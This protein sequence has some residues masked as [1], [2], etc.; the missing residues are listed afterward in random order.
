MNSASLSRRKF[1]KNALA[2]TA[3]VAAPTIVPAS[4]FGANA[5]SNRIALGCIGVGRMGQGDLRSFM[6]FPEIQVVAVCDVDSNRAKDA[7]RIVE[8]KYAADKASGTYKGCAVTGDFREVTSRKD[9]DAVMICTP[10]HWHVLPAIAA[11]KAGKD[12][13]LQK[14]L[15]LT[16][17]EGRMLSDAVRRYGRVLLVGCQRRSDS[18]CRFGC[19]LVRNGRIG[20]LHTVKVGTGADPGTGLYPPTPPPENLDYDM[21]L[22]PAPWKPY[23]EQRVHPQKGYGRPGWLRV[24]DYSAGMVTGWGTHFMDIAHWGMGT[25]L[26]GPIEIEGEAE[27]PKD[28]VWD[29][30]GPFRIECKYANGVKVIY[31]DSRQVQQGIR[32][33]GTEGWVRV[34]HGQIEAEPKSLLTSKIKPGEIHLYESRNHKGNLIDCIKT[35][36]ETVAPVEVGHRTCSACLLGDIAMRLGRKLHWDPDRERFVNDPEA[37]RWIGRPMRGAWRL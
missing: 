11:A 3:A 13:F 22:G 36:A 23:I 16:I 35:R 14:P 7:L 31:G 19:E 25:E 37:D 17:E 33:E 27:F 29:V 5:P 30:H 2:A 15:S 6:G 1:L 4:V 8:Q 10:D 9:V 24:S 32:F 26:T 18:R 20:Q 21:W 12:I 34:G 28:G